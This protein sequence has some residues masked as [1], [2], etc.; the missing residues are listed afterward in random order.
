MA[1][2]KEEVMVYPTADVLKA[3]YRDQVSNLE[4]SVTKKIMEMNKMASNL[5]DPHRRIA[6]YS[7]IHRFVFAGAF[8]K[9]FLPE[10][11]S[12]L[13]ISLKNSSPLFNIAYLSRVSDIFG[14]AIKCHKAF[15]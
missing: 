2:E 14:C 9:R 7:D 5:N 8:G 13:G 6:S 1:T 15:G 12:M 11:K 10:E 3:F 4:K